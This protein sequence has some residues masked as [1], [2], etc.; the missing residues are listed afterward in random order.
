MGRNSVVDPGISHRQNVQIDG[1]N[2]PISEDLMEQSLHCEEYTGQL[3]ASKPAF[4]ENDSIASVPFRP[5]LVG[6]YLD[7]VPLYGSFPSALNGQWP[8]LAITVNRT[9]SRSGQDGLTN[10]TEPMK[11]FPDRPTAVTILTWL[12]RPPSH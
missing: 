2:T 4:I 10:Y 5:S 1:K 11:P 9:T 8:A 7:S 3:T 6:N 12:R